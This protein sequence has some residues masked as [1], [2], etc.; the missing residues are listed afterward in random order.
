VVAGASVAGVGD[1]WHELGASIGQ[2]R[3]CKKPS[4][5]FGNFLKVCLQS[6]RQSVLCFPPLRTLIRRSF[7]RVPVICITIYFRILY[8]AH[9]RLAVSFSLLTV[10]SES[11]R[12]SFLSPRSTC[13]IAKREHY[14][15]QD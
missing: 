10:N 13:D 5:V 11:G 12:L 8:P 4:S 9:A 7:G 6:L 3:D 1:G 15:R 14:T 2:E